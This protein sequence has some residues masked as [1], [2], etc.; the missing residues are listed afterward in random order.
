MNEY[1]IALRSVLRRL[2]GSVL[3]DLTGFAVTRWHNAGLPAVQSRRPDMPG[4]TADGTLV[5]IELQS[6]NQAG[7]ALRM[8]EYA[9]AIHR[10]FRRFP[11]QVLLYVGQA[12][13][14]M[15]R[16]VAGPQLTFSCKMADIRSYSDENGSGESGWAWNEA[17]KEEGERKLVLRQTGKRFGPVPAAA[18]KR[19]EGLSG[20]KLERLALRLPDAGSLDELLS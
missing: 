19:I 3:R 6:T 18:K 14:R 9:V 1:D 15:K 16:D 5:H 7:M 20:P 17:A 4:E 2:T 8:L 13:L 10:Q 12:P 11:Q